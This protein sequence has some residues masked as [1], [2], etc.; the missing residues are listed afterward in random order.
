MDAKERRKHH[1]R[2]A[3]EANAMEQKA[4]ALRARHERARKAL[5][6]A[7]K[8]EVKPPEDP[9]D[10]KHQSGLA[11]ELERLK[12][13]VEILTK[14]TT[15]KSQEELDEVTR[16]E[17]T[18][19]EKSLFGQFD[20]LQ[21]EYEVL[22]TSRPFKELNALHA[23][24]MD[25]EL[26]AKSGLR[27]TMPEASLEDL[28]RAAVDKYNKDP[29]FA[30]S[31]AAYPITGEDAERFNTLLS[32]HHETATKGGDLEGNWLAKLK[33]SGQ[34]EEVLQKGRK[35]AAEDAAHRTVKAIQKATTAVQPV[36]PGDGAGGGYVDSEW[37]LSRA[38]TVQGALVKKHQSGRALTAPEREELKKANELLRTEFVG[39]E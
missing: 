28:R 32:L 37:N 8:A 33:R 18:A 27:Q 6:E 24:W 4:A 31:V 5:E 34:L 30:K 20:D 3:D 23:D 29:E 12:K 35:E 10:E 17:L 19:R 26:V 14:Q 39:A 25:T 1:Q 13:Q 7:Q 15:E 38:R 21:E 2:L 9:W 22:K 11:T 36:A 16:S